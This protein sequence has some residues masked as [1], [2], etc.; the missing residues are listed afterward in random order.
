MPIKLSVVIP[1]YNEKERFK[2]GLDHFLSYLNKQ[3]YTWELVLINDGSIDNT[4]GQMKKIAKENKSVKI[5]SYKENKGKGYAIVQGVKHAKGQLILFSDLDHSVPITTIESFFRYFE[6]GYDVVIGS[7]RVEGSKF[8]KRQNLLR[9]N[10]GR[11]FTLLVRIIID[12]PIKDATCGFKAFTAQAAKKIFSS[13]SIYGW[14]FDAELL[15]LC[16]KYGCK[17]AQAPVIWQDVKGSKVS[18]RRDIA[19]SMI[20]LVKIRI[21]DLKKKYR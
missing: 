19:G 14:A 2:D 3:K 20:G 11:G 13:I 4:L 17:Y 1:C 7:R 21:N 15:F 12:W 5:V 8:I 18:L 10:L 16:K 6:K 9:E